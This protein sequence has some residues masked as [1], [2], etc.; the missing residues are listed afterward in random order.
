MSSVGQVTR[1][2]W[3][4]D[5]IIASELKPYFE[6]EGFRMTGSYPLPEHNQRTVEY[7]R[8]IQGSAPGNRHCGY[9][10]EKCGELQAAV[11]HQLLCRCT[12]ADR[13]TVPLPADNYSLQTLGS[14]GNFFE[15]YRDIYLTATKTME[16][17]NR[18]IQAFLQKEQQRYQASNQA[19]QQRMRNNQASFEATQRAY[20]E[21][22]DAVNSSMMRV[23]IIHSHNLPVRD[24]ASMWT[25]FTGCNPIQT[26]TR[27]PSTS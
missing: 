6:K 7:S 9:G 22:N 13:W 25:R 19:F 16:F 17:D 21:A 23:Y 20:T 24:K 27:R 4:V 2:V 12:G 11:H 26:N 18:A 3:T 5:D 14:N 10:M 8:R 1:K 15:E